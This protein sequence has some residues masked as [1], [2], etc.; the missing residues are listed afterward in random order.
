MPA[1]LD[2][3]TLT[4]LAWQRDA[5]RAILSPR[6]GCYAWAGGRGSGKSL[7]VDAAACMLA[8]TRP[9]AEVAL[10]MDSYPSLRDIHLPLIKP[11]AKSCGGQWRATDTEFHWPSGSVVR[12]RHL[13]VA[14]DPSLGGSPIEGG[15]YHAIIADECQQVDRAYWDLFQTRYRKTITD[16]AG[17][18]CGPVLVTSGLRIDPWWCRGTAALGGRVWYPATRENAANN[19][20][21]YED[22]MRASMTP[23]RARAL[24]DADGDFTPEGGCFREYVPASED[25]GGHWTDW[26]PADLRSTRFVL[27][28]D[29]GI[30]WPHFGLFAQDQ[31]RGRWV[32]I[33]EWAPDDATVGDVCRAMRRE[34]IPRSQWDPMSGLF[35]VDQ[36]I[37][38]PAGRARGAD[39][40]SQADLFALPA[41]EGFGMRPTWEQDQARC[42]VA[43]GI[44]RVNMALHRKAVMFYRPMMEAG[45]KAHHDRRTLARCMVG[46]RWDPRRPGEPLKDN[47]NDHGADVVRYFTRAFLWSL[48]ADLA[49]SIRPPEPTQRAAGDM[50]WDA[51]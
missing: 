27:V 16:L 14:G 1:P 45:M 51:R 17:N 28:G 12:L 11:L 7:L 8:A 10:V 33:R 46:Y 2:I 19:D 3:G 23:E 32:C 36:L 49:A 35:P 9:G 30:R 47:R 42:G 5:L 22:R 18:A 39:G 37:I 21:G 4:P 44:D 40:R 48:G 41:P 13:D 25:R 6:S 24:I 15:N 43:D 29:L 26:Q 34:C 38:D 50:A 20:A 31:E